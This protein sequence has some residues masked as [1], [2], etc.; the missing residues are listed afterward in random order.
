MPME[1]AP[2]LLVSLSGEN[3]TRL[4][5]GNQASRD[6]RHRGGIALLG[7]IGGFSALFI[8]GGLVAGLLLDRAFHTSFLFLLVGVLG[9]FGA[10]MF[11]IIR[12]AMKE[13]SE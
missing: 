2:K 12:V 9:G 7:E 13:L 3:K 10:T 6:R 4:S 5:R 11:M 8:V 1:Q